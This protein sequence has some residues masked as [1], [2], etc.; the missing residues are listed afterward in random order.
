M[1]VPAE[2]ALV[3]EPKP[4][5]NLGNRIVSFLQHFHRVRHADMIQ[6]TPQRHPGSFLEKPPEDRFAHAAKG[7]GRAERNPCGKLLA[8]QIEDRFEPRRLLLSSQEFDALQRGIAKFLD[9]YAEQNQEPGL[10]GRF[11]VKSA[12]VK[13]ALEQMTQRLVGCASLIRVC[14]QDLRSPFHLSEERNQKRV[15]GQRTAG[16]EHALLL[17]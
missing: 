14:P 12:T 16:G 10:A 15:V 9:H 17:E 11:P 8:H 4:Q 6:I 3:T 13:M 1:K 5:G 2:M 7:G